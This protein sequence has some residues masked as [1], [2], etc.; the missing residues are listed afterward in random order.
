MNKECTLHPFTFYFLLGNWQ[1]NPG[2]TQNISQTLFSSFSSFLRGSLFRDLCVSPI[3]IKNHKLLTSWLR[4]YTIILSINYH[5]TFDF[6]VDLGEEIT[7]NSLTIQ[8][9][10]KFSL[11]RS[12]GFTEEGLF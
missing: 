9:D 7:N 10:Q 11:S 12:W 3:A 6:Y 2:L 8:F 5:H 4:F 1:I